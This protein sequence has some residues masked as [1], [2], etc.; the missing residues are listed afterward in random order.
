MSFTTQALYL[1]MISR[2]FYRLLPWKHVTKD[3]FING[4]TK[5]YMVYVYIVLKHEVQLFIL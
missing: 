5:Q 1:H 4:S 2:N 3:M